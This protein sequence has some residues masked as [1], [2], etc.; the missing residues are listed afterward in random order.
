MRY[1]EKVSY[2]GIEPKPVKIKK[3]KVNYGKGTVRKY[4]RKKKKN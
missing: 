2:A 4:T 1:R 3:A